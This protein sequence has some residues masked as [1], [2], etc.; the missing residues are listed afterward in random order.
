MQDDESYSKEIA[1][2]L[3]YCMSAMEERAGSI[4]VTFLP[5]VKFEEDLVGETH[6]DTHQVTMQDDEVYSKE[7]ARLLPYCMTSISRKGVP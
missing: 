6:Q 2:L 1:R 4:V 7:I 5:A 3:P